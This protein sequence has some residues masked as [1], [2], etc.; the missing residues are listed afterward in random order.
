[1]RDSASVRRVTLALLVLGS[2]LTVSLCYGHWI[3]QM[4][5]DLIL[6]LEQAQTLTETED[7]E[8][9]IK[10]TAA[11]KED[12][13]SHRFVLHAS[14]RHTEMD[15]ILISLLA[16]SAYLDAQETDQYTASNAQL[17]AKLQLLAEMESASWA[18]VL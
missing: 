12:W 10:I 7:W 3:K 4:T 2:I 11:V 18:N 1:M 16:V 13:D 14:M 5:D 15:Q 9:A 6:R 17:I 8:G